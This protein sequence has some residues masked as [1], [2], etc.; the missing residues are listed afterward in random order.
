MVNRI[1]LGCIIKRYRKDVKISITM[2]ANYI[3]VSVAYISRLEN[4]LCNVTLDD[5][6]LFKI[7]SII[8]LDRDIL[9]RFL[10]DEVRDML[11]SLFLDNVGPD[12]R[13]QYLYWNGEK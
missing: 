8:H 13:I 12:Q 5:D 2:L 1:G 7:A 6:K 9:Q 11:G 10:G 4:G 3:D